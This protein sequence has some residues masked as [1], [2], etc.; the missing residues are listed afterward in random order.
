MIQ[1]PSFPVEPWGI[2]E[3]E[4]HLDTLAETESVFAL[5]NGHL[6][7]RGNFDEGEPYGLP[8]TYLGGFFETRPL[9]YAEAGYGYP[10]DGQTVVNV[11]NG[12]LISL[13]VEDEPFDLRYGTVVSHQR[14][15]DFRAGTLR[16]EVEW[17]SPTGR[18]VRVTTTRL[19]SFTQRAVAL[20]DYTVEP[21][22]D[23]FPVVLQ[24]LLVA[25]EGGAG[26]S[27]DPRAAAALSAP[28][29]AELSGCHEHRAILV[30][31]TKSSDLRV[32]A[33]M[34]HWVRR[35]GGD[36]D[37][38]SRASPTWPASRSRPISPPATRCGSSSCWPTAGLGSA[39]P[40]RCATRSPPPRP[41]PAMSAGRGCARSSAPTWTTSGRAQTSS[42]R[43]TPSSSRH[44]L[45]PVPHPAGG[46]PGRAAGDRGQGPDRT[47]LRRTHVLGHRDVRA[48]RAHLHRPA[49]PRR[50]RCAGARA[51]SSSPARGRARWA[52][53]ARPSPGGRFGARSARA[54]GRRAPGA[55]HINADIANAV[56][57]YLAATGDQAFERDTGLELLVET[58][59]LWRSLGH[60]DPQGRFRIDGVT[61]PDEY[62]AVADNNVYTNLMAQRNLQAAA[63]V[64]ERHPDRAERPGGR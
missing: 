46:R 12:K 52:C 44:P 33:A 15:L 18:R 37:L 63:D 22:D 6:G 28:L 54:T 7:L 5:S 19:V 59:R 23:E 64:A 51:R 62:S 30:H 1:H 60:H 29:V 49:W 36:P 55:F 35:S 16:R 43:A 34:D 53:A 17:V 58:A 27:E 50:T 8:G 61:G 4:L 41:V 13:L 39:R 42:S 31:R 47:G 11:T 14:F 45:R 21:V 26:A 9:P 38:R 56:S 25:N 24:S 20:I 10:E 57:R 3:T 40:T 32:A 2:R 48:L